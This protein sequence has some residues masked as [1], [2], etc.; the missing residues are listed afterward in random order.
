M[1]TEIVHAS[2]LRDKVARR[3]VDLR[4]PS[5]HKEY[6]KNLAAYKRRLG[7]KVEVVS[8]VGTVFHEG[9]ALAFRGAVGFHVV[10]DG[11]PEFVE[12]PQLGDPPML[13]HMGYTRGSYGRKARDLGVLP[14]SLY[15]RDL[16]P[17]R[18]EE[19]ETV[20]RAGKWADLLSDPLTITDDGQVVNGQH[21]IAA[22]VRVD[23]SD[24]DN[25][26]S[27]LVVWGVSPGEALLADGSRRTHKDEATIG[28]K[29][30]SAVANSNG[31]VR[32]RRCRRDEVT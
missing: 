9:V 22:C 7:K 12:R 28:V 5:R 3:I 15:N 23:W 24:V 25:D 21:R 16:R 30:A 19:Y 2:E 11:K 13:V 14:N 1:K 20:M 6:A 26:P 17:Q 29:I 4:E 10:V 8:R 18:V 27:F 32:V 31:L